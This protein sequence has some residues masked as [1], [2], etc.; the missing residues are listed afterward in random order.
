M[1]HLAGTIDMSPRRLQRL[2]DAYVGASPK[3][4]I[5]RYRIQEAAARAARGPVAWAQLAVDLGY[6]DQA[7]FVRDFVANVGVTPTQYTR[8]CGAGGAQPG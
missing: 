6:S 3:W 8:L 2:F 1:A 5:R 7:H 4:V